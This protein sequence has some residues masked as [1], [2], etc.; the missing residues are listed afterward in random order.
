MTSAPNAHIIP[1]LFRTE[2]TR[3]VSVLCKKFGLAHIETAEDLA[4]ETF[5]A[6]IETWPYR[7]VPENPQAWLYTVARNKAKNFIARGNALNKVAAD[8]NSTN[9]TTTEVEIDL[10]EANIRDSRLRMMFAICHPAIPAEAQIGLALRILCGFGIDEIASAFLTNRETIIKRLFRAREKLRTENITVVFPDESQLQQRLVNVLTTL[11]LLFSEGYYSESNNSIIREDLCFEAMRLT[12]LLLESRL[13]NVPAANALMALMCFH[14]SRLKSRRDKDGM[15]ILYNNQD[16]RL[17]DQELIAKGAEYLRIAS[18]GQQLTKYHLEGH[19]AYWDTIKADTTEK[20]N[21]ILQL[22]N[23]LLM[24]EYS[25][26]AA[27]NRT[28]ALFKVKG[29]AEAIA[30]AE[31]LQLTDNRFYFVL[32]GELYSGQNDDLARDNFRKAL[33]L[34]KTEHD[35]RT[36]TSKLERLSQSVSKP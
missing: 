35:R 14:A 16:E 23:R 18:T 8:L 1:H 20:W 36:I 28:Y 34:T 19:I 2:F 24:L 9:A 17:W 32:L 30:E 4:S 21:N 7:G 11:Y 12:N 25:P 29:K 26:V 15:V 5:L 3:I 33:K 27:L 13:T 31:K 10:S 22:Y 6:A